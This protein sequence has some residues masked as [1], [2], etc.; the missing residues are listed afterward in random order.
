[1]SNI[2]NILRVKNVNVTDLKKVL[3][4]LEGRKTTILTQALSQFSKVV[5]KAHLPI[6]YQT[7][8]DLR[9]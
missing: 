1:M 9:F 5:K 7:T 6:G 8:N 4:H 3:A 2:E